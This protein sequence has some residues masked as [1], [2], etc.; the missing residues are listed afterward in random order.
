M[1]SGWLYVASNTALKQ[2]KIGR[3]E[4]RPTKRRIK[5]LFTTGVP[6]EFKCEYEVKVKNFKRNDQW[7]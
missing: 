7:N 6:E 4:K 1:K 3:S 2:I 5:E